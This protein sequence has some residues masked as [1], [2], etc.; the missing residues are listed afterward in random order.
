LKVGTGAEA[1]S[2]LRLGNTVENLSVF[3]E[4]GE[5]GVKQKVKYC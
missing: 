2:Y 3:S 5:K 1:N 4:E